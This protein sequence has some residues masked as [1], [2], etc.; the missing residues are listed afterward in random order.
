MNLPRLSDP[1]A[2]LI[3]TGYARYW[4]TAPDAPPVPARLVMPASGT[5]ARYVLLA[6][7]G[8]ILTLSP[9][10]WPLLRL[11]RSY[12]PVLYAPLPSEFELK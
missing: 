7:D 2:T 6:D 11:L 12:G 10:A 1:D 5:P 4:H 3:A 8:T 9:S